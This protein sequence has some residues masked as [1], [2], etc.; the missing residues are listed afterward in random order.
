MSKMK[1]A[2]VHEAGDVSISIEKRA[3][4]KLESKEAEK[5]EISAAPPYPPWWGPD[6]KR[7]APSGSNRIDSL[8]ATT[9]RR[10]LLHLSTG[11]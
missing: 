6:V 9:G 11:L 5:Q 1:S 3:E 2:R 10:K 4:K 7:V 8:F